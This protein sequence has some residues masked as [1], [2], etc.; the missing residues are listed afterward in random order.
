MSETTTTATLIDWQPGQQA[1]HCGHVVTLLGFPTSSG[2]T[3][4]KLGHHC[5]LG[6]DC[7]RWDVDGGP[8]AFAWECELTELPTCQPTPDTADF[9]HVGAEM[10]WTSPDGHITIVVRR[11][12]FAYVVETYQ[13]T[14]RVTDNCGSYDDETTA[15]A[16]ARGYAQMYRAE[17]TTVR[18][19]ARPVARGHQLD[20]SEYE[21]AL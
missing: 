16:V 7:R 20:M 10:P 4:T 11:G 12:H 18:V 6:R 1:R 13:G 17:V 15:R 19:T 3:P 8:A 2:Y 21:A 9:P 5:P 14:L